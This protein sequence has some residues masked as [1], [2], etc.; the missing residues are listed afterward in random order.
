MHYLILNNYDQLRATEQKTKK[1]VYWGQLDTVK[2]V[3]RKIES[4]S[5]L[6][7]CRCEERGSW[8]MI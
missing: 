5:Y 1:K 8:L 3:I 2:F 4:N 6:L 7:G